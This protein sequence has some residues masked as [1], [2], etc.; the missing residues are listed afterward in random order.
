[1][2]WLDKLE[3]KWG[4][5]GIPNITTLFL[6]TTIIGDFILYAASAGSTAATLLY[7]LLQFDAGLILRGQVWRIF[8]WIFMP[9]NGLSFWTLLFMLCL[10][11]LG[12]SLEQGLGTF[13]M[14][15]YF[16]GGWLLSTLGGLIIYLIFNVSIY[17]TPYYILFSLYLMLGIFMPEAES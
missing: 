2:N 11:W 8:T 10:F 17:L 3:Q 12:K 15:V 16:I 1:M 9:F 14:N 5:K 6:F 13:K 4:N 7:S